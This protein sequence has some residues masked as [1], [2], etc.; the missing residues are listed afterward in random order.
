MATIASYTVVAVNAQ[1][2]P[3]DPWSFTEVNL[4][5]HLQ[6]ITPSEVISPETVGGVYSEFEITSA[7]EFEEEVSSNLI[8]PYRELISDRVRSVN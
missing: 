1:H 5:V 6:S 2:D 8:V 7:N 3:Q 4:F